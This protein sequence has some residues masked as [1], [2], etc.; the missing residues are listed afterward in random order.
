MLARVLQKKR[1]NRMCVIIINKGI[2]FKQ[3]ARII[4]EPW[5]SLKS[6][7]GD[8]QVGDSGKSCS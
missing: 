5:Q 8:W 6:N 7:G 3:L 2:Y 1:A 4:V